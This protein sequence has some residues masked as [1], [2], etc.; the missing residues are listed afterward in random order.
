MHLSY[1]S[2]PSPAFSAAAISGMA[3]RRLDSDIVG[4]G[5]FDPSVMNAMLPA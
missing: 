1:P 2:I 5:D 4:Y 3:E